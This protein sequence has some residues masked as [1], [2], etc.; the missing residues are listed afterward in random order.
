VLLWHGTNDL[1]EIT[2]RTRRSRAVPG[3]HKRIHTPWKNPNGAMSAGNERMTANTI[4]KIIA[5][6]GVVLMLAGCGQ[7]GLSCSGNGGTTHN[8]GALCAGVIPLNW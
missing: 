7:P 4:T 3:A 1:G 5:L 8:S 2:E 6:C